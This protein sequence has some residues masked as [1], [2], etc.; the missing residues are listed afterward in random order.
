M[1]DKR[2]LDLRKKVE[3]KEKALGIKPKADY[4]SNMLYSKKQILVMSLTEI[5]DSIADI[6]YKKDK[7]QEANKLL[8]VELPISGEQ[9]LQDLILRGKILSWENSHKEVEVLRYKLD[10]LRSEDLRISDELD[11]LE[12]LLS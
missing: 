1:S 3:E 9:Y 4:K 7:Q 6:L 5:R 8:N 10:S 2:V 12:S 11:D